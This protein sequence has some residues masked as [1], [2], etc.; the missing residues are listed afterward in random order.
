VLWTCVINKKVV[1]IIQDRVFIDRAKAT[2]IQV[3]YAYLLRLMMK[4]FLNLVLLLNSRHF[5]GWSYASW[6]EN[7]FQN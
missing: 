2:Y 5:A 1:F 3:N 6:K 7:K 4:Y